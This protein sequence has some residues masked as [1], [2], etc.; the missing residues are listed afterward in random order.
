MRARIRLL[1]VI[2]PTDL[3]TGRHVLSNYFALLMV[4]LMPT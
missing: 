3:A 2:S 4:A 1:P